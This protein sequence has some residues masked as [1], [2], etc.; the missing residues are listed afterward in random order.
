MHLKRGFF[1]R[2]ET[3]E[4]SRAETP[5]GQLIVVALHCK[6]KMNY[7]M[8]YQLYDLFFENLLLIEAPSKISRRK[9]IP[10]FNFCEHSF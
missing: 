8:K 4:T 10:P 6:Q 1:I 3:T 7:I 2:Y 9:P 5:N